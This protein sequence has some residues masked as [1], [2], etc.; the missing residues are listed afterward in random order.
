MMKKLQLLVN[1]RNVTKVEHNDIEILSFKL[2]QLHLV[3]HSVWR[4]GAM[5][6]GI[7]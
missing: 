6:I 4:K 7:V 5:K 3:S 2:I 1:V